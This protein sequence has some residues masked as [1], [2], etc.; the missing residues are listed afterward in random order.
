MIL[1]HVLISDIKA[2]EQLTCGLPSVEFFISTTEMIGH[3][4][5]GI[6]QR[7]KGNTTKVLAIGLVILIVL[8]VLLGDKILP[9]MASGFDFPATPFCGYHRQ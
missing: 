1:L 8:A 3:P 2:L 6:S 5:I 9:I 7:K 4:V